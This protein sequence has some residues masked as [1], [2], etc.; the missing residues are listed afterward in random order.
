MFAPSSQC[1]KSIPFSFP[2][3]PFCGKGEKNISIARTNK[4]TNTTFDPPF[5]LSQQT[6]PNQQLI[7]HYKLF[8]PS[9][10][11][12]TNFEA[13]TTLVHNCS[14][15]WVSSIY[16][17][18]HPKCQRV[19]WPTHSKHETHPHNNTKDSFLHKYK[20]AD[21]AV[22]VY[23]KPIH[24][25]SKICNLHLLTALFAFANFLVLSLL[26]QQNTDKNKFVVR[27]THAF[28]SQCYHRYG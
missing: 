1:E 25:Q 12:D 17:S 19:S 6:T 2:W 28:F 16:L 3:K 5:K 14:Y 18:I 24:T 7:R 15:Q 10:H 26:Y 13:A 20:K 8:H 9:Y 21:N 22:P 27:L 23:D 11:D 4:Q